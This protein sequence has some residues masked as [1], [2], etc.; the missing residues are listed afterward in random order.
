LLNGE[1]LDGIVYAEY[2]IGRSR[3]I[4]KADAM[5]FRAYLVLLNLG[6]GVETRE[7]DCCEL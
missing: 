4:V 2:A 3:S 1:F 7:G 6:A 5:F